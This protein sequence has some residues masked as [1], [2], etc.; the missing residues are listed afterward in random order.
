MEQQVVDA[1]IHKRQTKWITNTPHQQDSLKM[2]PAIRKARMGKHGV[3]IQPTR[4]NKKKV[5]A[6]LRKK[7]ILPTLLAQVQSADME[8][9]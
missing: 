3:L 4:I 6:M 1:S 9:N 8:M 2:V 5:K 7:G